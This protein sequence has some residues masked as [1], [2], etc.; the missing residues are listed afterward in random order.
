VD[1][2]L[3][4]A[5]SGLAGAAIGGAMSIL[6]SW[7]VNERGVRAQWLAQDKSRREDLYKEFIEEASKCYVDALMHDKPNTELL[8]VLHAKMSRMRVL[9]SPQVLTAADQV[10]RGIIETYLKPNVT[11]SREEIVSISH[12]GFVDV[13]RDFGETCRAELASLRA[14]Q[15]ARRRTTQ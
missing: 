8:V 11:L 3:I 13:T 14:Q 5:A 10:I 6:G 9:S 12:G 4:S 7:L 2:S 1:P 15:F